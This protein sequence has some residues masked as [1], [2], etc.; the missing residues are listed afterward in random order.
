MDQQC[1]RVEDLR[2]AQ[3]DCRLAQ[4]Q[5][6]HAMSA[7]AER[8]DAQTARHQRRVADLAVAI[9]RRMDLDTERLEGLYLGA[10]VHDIGK[11]GIPHDI[12]AKPGPLSPGERTVMQQ[13][14]QL[15]NDI[16]ASVI[17]P[18]PIHLIAGQHHERLDGSGYPNGLVGEQILLESRI[19]AVADVFQSMCDDRPYRQALPVV[20]ALDELERGE[21][22]RYESAAVCA[23][24]AIVAHAEHSTEAL[25]NRFAGE[26]H[27]L[28][29]RVRHTA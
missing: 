8:R 24:S 17:L 26:T 3:W 1:V 28:I 11:I 27:S 29:G 19:V 16:L 25:W 18:W 5:T 12:L 7:V 14:A 4:I 13:H 6:V 22:E 20:V 23:L 2:Q 10:L 21:G 15:G 9:G